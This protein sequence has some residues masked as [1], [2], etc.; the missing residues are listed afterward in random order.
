MTFS[1]ITHHVS[2]KWQRYWADSDKKS[3][4]R[5]CRW[6]KSRTNL[7]SLYGRDGQ[8]CKGQHCRCPENFSAAEPQWAVGKGTSWHAHRELQAAFPF[9]SQHKLSL[10]KSFKFAYSLSCSW[11]SDCL[12]GLGSRPCHRPRGKSE[13][14]LGLTP[15]QVSGK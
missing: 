1:L 8:S 7:L 4:N 12:L 2:E 3:E 6:N 14:F 11:C 15:E 9:K 10:D 5:L 13:V